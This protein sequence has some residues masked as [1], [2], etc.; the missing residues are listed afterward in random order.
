MVA[1]VGEKVVVVHFN[2]EK[3]MWALQDVVHAILVG[4]GQLSQHSTILEL[5]I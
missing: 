4:D 5:E 1:F 2:T 3:Y